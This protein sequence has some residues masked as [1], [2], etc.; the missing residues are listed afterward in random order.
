MLVTLK[1]G[2]FAM[3]RA[4]EY[5]LEQG[6]VASPT[7]RFADDPPQYWSIADALN[8]RPRRGDD[9]AIQS[10]K[11][12]LGFNF[13]VLSQSQAADLYERLKVRGRNDELSRAFYHALAPATIG[14]LLHI[15]RLVRDG[16]LVSDDMVR[17]ILRPRRASREYE[18]DP[19]YELERMSSTPTI[20]APRWARI[21]YVRR[22][23]AA[24]LEAFDPR[25]AEP[26][27]IPL[28]SFSFGSAALTS[29][30]R[31]VISRIATAAVGR[32]PLT[33]GLCLIIDLEGHEDEVGDPARFGDLGLARAVAVTRALLVSIDQ[34]RRRRH[35]A[36]PSIPDIEF[37]LSTAGPARP[38][39]SNV[40]AGGRALNR[41]V[42]VRMRVQVC[43]GF[44]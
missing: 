10:R 9:R 3:L 22:N 31:R 25:P 4:R 29:A 33:S 40:T 23:Q 16:Q 44:V 36:T 19:L 27:T 12:D 14:Q 26:G 6:Y 8:K 11:E 37:H 15:L 42:E 41:R 32:L 20:A 13:A 24:E 43:T 21:R 34:L 30:H 17:A 35:I 1:R 39:R 2:G 5:E 7:R 28:S 18:A 38:I